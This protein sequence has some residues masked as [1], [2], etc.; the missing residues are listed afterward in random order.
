MKPCY[1]THEQS[2]QFGRRA[3]EIIANSK[4]LSAED[5][6]NIRNYGRLSERLAT[7]PTG[8]DETQRNRIGD[9]FVDVRNANAP[10][11]ASRTLR[12]NAYGSVDL[13]AATTYEPSATNLPWGYST[14]N[15]MRYLASLS[16]NAAYVAWNSIIDEASN[17]V[18]SIDAYVRVLKKIVPDSDL[19]NPA[20]VG[21]QTRGV[22]L[23]RV[24]QND[25]FLRSRSA[26]T[27]TS[28]KSR[29]WSSTRRSV[30]IAILCGYAQLLERKER[31]VE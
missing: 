12:G 31:K 29:P 30:A 28:T 5:F 14:I 4:E 13:P 19:F 26:A 9:F 3:A 22:I 21:R 20:L 15:H 10:V 2:V 23:T 6:A 7:V 24:C 1:Y 17:I 11:G 16:G 18:K 27:R 8:L 25:R